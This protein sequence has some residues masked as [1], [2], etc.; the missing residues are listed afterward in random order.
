MP[1][2]KTT[3]TNMPL[4]FWRLLTG[5]AVLVFLFVVLKNGWVAEDAYI[6]FRSI[7]QLYAGNGP[8]WNP[9][10]RVQVFTSP[11]WYGLLAL[12][13]SIVHNLYELSLLIS[14]ALT[15][16]LLWVLYRLTDRNI[17]SWA[18]LLALL[19]GSNA[20]M[21]FTTSGLE[22]PLAYFLLALFANFYQQLFRG[23]SVA[24][25]VVALILVSGLLVLCRMDLA[26]LVA[27]ALLF[28]VY[29]F[30][31]TFPIRQWL[32]WWLLCSVPVVLWFSFAF[33]YYGDIFPNTA[34][35]KLNTGLDTSVLLEQGLRY[36]MH[37][38]RYDL[39][40]MIVVFA[41]VLVGFLRKGPAAFL[42]AG[43]LL[44]LLYVLSVG[45]DFMQGRF[46][47]CAYLLAAILL[48]QWPST[49]S[50][51]TA[52]IALLLVYGI[53]YPHTPLNSPLDYSDG[54]IHANGIADE[55]GYY[56]VYTGLPGYLAKRDGTHCFVD[57]DWG[58]RALVPG[59][60]VTIMRNIG[61]FGACEAG[62]EPIL[63]DPLGITDPFL[64]RLPLDSVVPWRIGHF[65]RSI[66][67]GYTESVISGHNEIVDP[68][69][70]DLYEQT[71]IKTRSEALL[72]RERLAV[73]LGMDR[74]GFQ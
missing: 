55:R 14:V 39:L 36:F 73:L 40:T 62:L 72:S 41:A 34:Y 22:N 52:C 47:S 26:T 64:S 28:A 37:T 29:R 69:L 3:T 4:N 9:H 2:P 18:L 68:A 24:R 20:F 56:F 32:G 61:Y 54:R 42:A 48:L 7:E 17:L 11:L 74:S 27:P 6:N 65:E 51:R 21:D 53:L 33:L 71:V 15:A 67:A 46:F 60:Q 44:N 19:L 30:R 57:F 16:A 5:T 45:G 49:T 25:N 31:H 59:Q 12:G 58:D 1:A 70:R 8:I 23:E 50:V 66:P 43:I 13:R 35:A 63:I 38:A 10:E